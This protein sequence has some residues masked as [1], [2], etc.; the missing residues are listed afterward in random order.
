M[1]T[2]VTFLLIT[3]AL[4][5]SAAFAQA[6][7]G[8]QCGQERWAI[9]TLTDNQADAVGHAT[10]QD[11]TVTQ[12]IG[13]TAPAKLTDTRAPGETKLY[14]LKALIVG[15][16]IE[17][18]TAAENFGMAAS[19]VPSVPD[20]DF[21]IVIADPD[22]PT[23]QMIMEVPDPQCQAVCSS[24]FLAQIQKVRTEVSSRLGQPMD[25]LQTLPKPWLVDVTG[26]AF[27]DFAHGQDGL[28]KNCI[29]IHPVIALNFL[30]Q[31]GNAVQP[32]KAGDLSHKCGKR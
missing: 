24:K 20:H 4:S 14:H 9:K 2:P 28:A 25:V 1:R 17:A 32:H 18:Q 7:C 31:Q 27:F 15:W 10:P 23:N 19:A 6:N 3:I 16:K 30:S 11:S 13:Q 8:M 5:G 29:E 21:H 12:L 26:P 22:N